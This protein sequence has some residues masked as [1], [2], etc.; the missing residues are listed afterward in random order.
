[1]FQILYS[2]ANGASLGSLLCSKFRLGQ[3]WLG[4][5][6]LLNR[7]MNR[8]RQYFGHPKVICTIS[9]SV[10]RKKKMYQVFLFAYFDSTFSKYKL[11]KFNRFACNKDLK[12][13]LSVFILIYPIFYK[14]LAL[15][16]FSNEK[17]LSKHV[18]LCH[19]EENS[20]MMDYFTK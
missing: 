10:I 13:K 6:G 15:T 4:S 5:F 17:S 7:G 1:M 11:I 8:N 3:V 19:S 12:F 20:K 2:P 18:S 16:F 14:K 9:A